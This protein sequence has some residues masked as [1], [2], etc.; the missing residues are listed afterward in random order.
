[1]EG[2]R[3]VLVAGGGYGIGRAVALRFAAEGHHVALL[4]R[5]LDRLNDTATEIERL[6]GRSS[7]INVDL[8][9]FERTKAAIDSH[10]EEHGPLS[11]LWNGA[12]GYVEG[13]IRE[14]AMD[15]V[16]SLFAGGVLGA[17][18]LTKQFLLHSV[19]QPTIFQVVADWG[20]PDTNGLASFVAAKKAVEG[21]GIALQKELHGKARITIV[22]PADV[23]SHSH[24]HS[25]S[26]DDVV[27]E[28]NGAAIAPVELAD[29]CFEIS[30]YKSLFV[31][32]LT[33]L[34]L[35]QNYA[36]TYL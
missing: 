34:P 31:H 30:R 8:G 5:N 16:D 27:A 20:F 13:P 32:K 10:A 33:I 9:D 17:I 2:R 36:V 7:V 12:F 18:N 28:T 35:N 15:D 21:F 25:A 22:S 4:G 23:A 24:G 1:M 26:A 14:L 11:I 3:G 19:E 6:G 29:L